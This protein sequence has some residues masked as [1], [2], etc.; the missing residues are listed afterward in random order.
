RERVLRDGV[1]DRGRRQ[2]EE[3]ERRP[4]P[5]SE[6]SRE[7]VGEQ[8]QD[9]QHEPG[10]DEGDED[11]EAAHQYPAVLPKSIGM[12]APVIGAAS[13]EARYT[14]SAATSSGRMNRARSRC[15]Y[16]ASSASRYACGSPSP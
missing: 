4:E 15:G 2:D 7:V 16:F 10:G 1:R 14:M 6:R 8:P 5:P 12:H 9:E 11:D 3:A 13:G